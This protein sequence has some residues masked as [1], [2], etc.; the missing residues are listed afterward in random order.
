MRDR[1]NNNTP[2]QCGAVSNNSPPTRTTLQK[3]S[4]LRWN[5]TSERPSRTGPVWAAGSLSLAARGEGD[6]ARLPWRPRVKPWRVAMSPLAPPAL[7]RAQDRKRSCPE[8]TCQTSER[9]VR[10]SAQGPSARVSHAFFF[11][12]YARVCTVL[13]PR[14]PK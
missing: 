8:P 9:A 7:P 12:K 14:D 4:R 5:F 11:Q 2:G 10:A 3:K 6:S 1:E 13:T